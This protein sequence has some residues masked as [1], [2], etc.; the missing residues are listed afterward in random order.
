MRNR[1]AIAP[2]AAFLLCLQGMCGATAIEAIPSLTPDGR[3]G[4][5]CYYKREKEGDLCLA[6]FYAVLAA[7]EKY[8]NR[9]ISLRG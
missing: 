7:P 6:S 3:F 8:D 1:L 2:L 9:Y 5:K 4:T